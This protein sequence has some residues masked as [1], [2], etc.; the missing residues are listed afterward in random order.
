MLAIWIRQR[1]AVK[2]FL[3]AKVCTHER[4]HGVYRVHHYPRSQAFVGDLETYLPQT[5]EATALAFECLG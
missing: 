4:K 2:C 5:R 1:A 3:C